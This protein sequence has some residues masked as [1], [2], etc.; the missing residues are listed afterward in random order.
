MTWYLAAD[1]KWRPLGYH[2]QSSADVC[3]KH[4]LN[5]RS[6]FNDKTANWPQIQPPFLA[7]K[8][9]PRHVSMAKEK[10]GKEEET[11]R[12]NT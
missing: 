6:I 11:S 1:A 3:A 10:Q 8:C 12:N 5:S 2:L 7:R 4:L 9:L